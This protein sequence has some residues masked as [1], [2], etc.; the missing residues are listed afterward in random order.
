MLNYLLKLSKINQ[1]HCDSSD[2]NRFFYLCEQ[3]VKR[4]GY[5]CKKIE[6]EI[7]NLYSET[8]N[9]LIKSNLIILLAYY[10][11]DL[12]INF[13]DDDLLDSYLFFLSF[14]K[15]YL[16]EKERIVK[17]LYQSYW[18]KNLY[19]ILKND[20]FKE[21]IE[22]F[23]DSDTQIN[24]KLKLMTNIN[25]FTNIDHFLKYLGD[26]NKY[27]CFLA[28]ELIYL[29]KEKGNN[30][31]IK[32]LQVDDLI[33]FL[34]FSFDFLE[35]KEEILCCVKEN[36]LC[37]LK[38][39]LKKYLKCV[40]DLKID[41]RVEGLKVFN[42]LDSGSELEVEEE[43]FDYLFDSSSYKDMCDCIE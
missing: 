8:T 37:R 11:V 4:E 32:E 29:Y 36:N 16:K 35:E 22:N 9:N 12:I 10:D 5:K 33:N 24:D 42:K 39:I 28:Y 25:Y 17:L 18:L 2:Y 20:E 26:K 30:L 23:I 7:I 1:S 19:L 34:Y 31:V 3:F 41:K 13:E 40:K 27:T 14:R 21:E 6:N 38:S 15:R 43:N